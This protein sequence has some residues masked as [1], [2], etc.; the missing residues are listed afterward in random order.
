[1][2]ASC[3]GE[4]RDLAWESSV[5]K[6]GYRGAMCNV[7][8]T[9]KDGP[10]FEAY[11]KKGDACERCSTL[12][13]GAIVNPYVGVS[14]GIVVLGTFL[15]K[16][17]VKRVAAPGSLTE[18]LSDG[19]SLEVDQWGH[20]RGSEVGRSDGVKSIGILK[21][22][23]QSQED[24]KRQLLAIQFA[25]LFQPLRIVIGFSQICSQLSTVLMVTMPVQ[26]SSVLQWLHENFFVD[27]WALFLHFDCLGLRSY[28]IRWILHVFIM[29]MFL[30]AIAFGIY[31]FQMRGG[32]ASAQNDFKAN[33]FFVIFLCCESATARFSC[34]ACFACLT[35]ACAWC[36]GR[37][38]HLHSHLPDLRVPAVQQGGQASGGG[39]YCIVQHRPPPGFLRPRLLSG[40]LRGCRRAAVPASV[41]LSSHKYWHGK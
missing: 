24:A 41:P 25:A 35:K 21:F 2:A 14:L 13:Q 29:P 3:T 33:I 37:P 18:G 39:L 32:H 11:G 15:R 19:N 36:V 20:Q 34:L 22:K 40:C 12:N 31:R 7:C 1:M 30:L 5:C 17:K 8:A 28:Y 27:L 4:G 16:R 26:I 9:V 38:L 6:P 10:S 23:V